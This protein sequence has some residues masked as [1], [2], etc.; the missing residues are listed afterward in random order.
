MMKPRRRLSVWALT[1]AVLALT[2]CRTPSTP[3]ETVISE[4]DPDAPILLR[5]DLGPVAR[6]LDRRLDEWAVRLI[7]QN[8][9]GE[10][11]MRLLSVLAGARLALEIPGTNVVRSLSLG[12]VRVTGRASAATHPAYLSGQGVIEVRPSPPFALRIE[13]PR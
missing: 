6:K 12:G 8:R 1:A 13:K 10:E 5:G 11:P 9:P 4:L 2:G 7:R 3:M